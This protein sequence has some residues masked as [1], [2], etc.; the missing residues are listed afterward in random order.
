MRKFCVLLLFFLLVL[1]QIL[2]Y[3]APNTVHNSVVTNGNNS[4]LCQY[5]EELLIHLQKH[6]NSSEVKENGWRICEELA[7]TNSDFSTFEWECLRIVDVDINLLRFGI[8]SS[9]ER[10]RICSF[11]TFEPCLFR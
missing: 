7:E 8:I 3:F 10:R 5:C 4:F 11:T 9:V 1:F 6:V 2:R